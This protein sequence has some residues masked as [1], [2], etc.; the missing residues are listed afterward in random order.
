MLH[1][2]KTKCNI[3]LAL[4]N[5]FMP[6]PTFFNLSLKALYPLFVIVQNIFKFRK[7]FVVLFYHRFVR[8]VLT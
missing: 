7:H 1:N 4:W 3:C 8:L 2:I 6:L 5:N